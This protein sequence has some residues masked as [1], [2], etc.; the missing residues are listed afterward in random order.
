MRVQD[1]PGLGLRLL[2]EAPDTD[3][4]ADMLAELLLIGGGEMD[5]DQ[6]IRDWYDPDA[7]IDD[8][9]YGTLALLS[10]SEGGPV[11]SGENRVVVDFGAD[12][13]RRVAL[14]FIGAIADLADHVGWGG[15]ALVAQV[16][17]QVPDLLDDEEEGALVG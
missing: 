8:S 3:L 10:R 11:L 4:R 13:W 12:E 7:S 5:Y 9:P 17:Q 6:L 16:L 14:T 2:D 1:N 15:T